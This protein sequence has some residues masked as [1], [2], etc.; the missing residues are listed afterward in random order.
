MALPDAGVTILSG[1][2]KRVIFD[3][4]VAQNSHFQ[5]DHNNQ[6]KWMTTV[7]NYLIGERWEMQDLF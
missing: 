3:K 1:A 5:F 6:E 4:K 7:K 2:G